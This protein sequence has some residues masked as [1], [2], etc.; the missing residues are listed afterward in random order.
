MTAVRFQKMGG[1]VNAEA[2][3]L[4]FMWCCTVD[5]GAHHAFWLRAKKTSALLGGL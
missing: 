5:I 3:L 2:Q 1:T 4:V